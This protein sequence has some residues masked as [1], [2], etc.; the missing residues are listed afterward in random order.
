MP[1][2]KYGVEISWSELPEVVKFSSQI[3]DTNIPL[4]SFMPDLLKWMQ[5]PAYGWRLEPYH[6]IIRMA[7][8]V[9]K[10][11]KKSDISKW[12]H[13][14]PRL[15]AIIEHTNKH[16]SIFAKTVITESVAHRYVDMF[17]QTHEV[18]YKDKFKNAYLKAFEHAKNGKIRKNQISSLF[19][20][21]EAYRLIYKADGDKA[22][23]K[24]AAKYYK[25][26][27]DQPSYGPV[28]SKINDSK[29]LYERYSSIARG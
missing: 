9:A 17:L 27:I 25:M 5:K 19:W 20:L 26:V 8:G 18:R 15:E 22:M 21:A 14:L 7:C 6:L 13:L 1:E 11:G 24:E 23:A 2:K 12:S 16:G 29:I 4:Q 3:A 10:K 28:I